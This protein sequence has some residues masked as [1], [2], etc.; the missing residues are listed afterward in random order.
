MLAGARRASSF[1]ER[2][3]SA[4]NALRLASRDRIRSPS[5]T[6]SLA[7]A[8][9][10]TL[11][12]GG[13]AGRAARRGAGRARLALL[14]L[15]V[16]PLAI[17]A[18]SSGLARRPCSRILQR[19]GSFLA[20]GLR[21]VPFRR[22]SPASFSVCSAHS[23]LGRIDGRVTTLRSRPFGN[24]RTAAF[25]LVPKDLRSGRHLINL[26]TRPDRATYKCS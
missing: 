4:G 18:T 6:P 14:E 26:V 2:G 24:L 12:S 1:R 5:M 10:R 16:R 7:L 19:V 15:G 8:A 22:R 17:R 11:S 9:N 20:G 25:L 3:I 13:T 23:G 21:S